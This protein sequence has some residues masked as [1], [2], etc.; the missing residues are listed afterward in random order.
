[1]EAIEQNARGGGFL[2]EDGD[3]S[4]MNAMIKTVLDEEGIVGGN[5]AGK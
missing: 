2:I 1:M 3:L 4:M 5:P